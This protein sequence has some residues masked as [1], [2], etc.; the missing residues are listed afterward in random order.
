M[1]Q[2]PVPKCHNQFLREAKTETLHAGIKAPKDSR[3]AEAVIAIVVTTQLLISL[4]GLTDKK[5]IEIT[6][7]VSRYSLVV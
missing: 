3:T 1:A 7:M 5:K 4:T 6:G 2:M